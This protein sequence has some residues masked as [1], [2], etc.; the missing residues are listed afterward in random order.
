[1]GGGD[2]S[3]RALPQLW[4]KGA[5]QHCLCGELPSWNSSLE[6]P[7]ASTA[8]PLLIV[9]LEKLLH[10]PQSLHRQHQKP[11]R[12]LLAFNN[13][14]LGRSFTSSSAE[15][16]LQAHQLK[17]NLHA[18]KT[19]C[20]AVSSAGWEGIQ[21]WQPGHSALHSTSC[22]RA[23]GTAS[24]SFLLGTFG[25]CSLFTAALGFLLPHSPHL[26]ERRISQ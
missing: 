4:N 17:Y 23:L 3:H 15:W 22:H 5:A 8:W 16:A 12:L 26:L 13:F 9:F 6:Q 19:D 7:G 10:Y 20:Q 1:M 25:P 2:A 18:G 14:L 24:F 21:S 11:T